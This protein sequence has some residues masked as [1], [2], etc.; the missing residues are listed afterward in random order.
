M[1]KCANDI[2]VRASKTFRENIRSKYS[3]RIFTVV[4][5]NIQ[6]ELKGRKERVFFRERKFI[7]QYR[8]L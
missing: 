6:K 5:S 8:I 1:V 3:K 2:V 4:Y 7:F